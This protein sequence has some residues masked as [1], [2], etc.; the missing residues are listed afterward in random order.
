LGRLLGL[1][2]S[3]RGASRGERLG[4][5]GIGPGLR[6]GLLRDLYL[7][8]LVGGGIGGVGDW[9]LVTVYYGV[10]NRIRVLG[11]VKKG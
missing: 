1:V 9:A 6:G 5:Y 11:T 8:E 3:L 7:V 2:A 10:G 4:S